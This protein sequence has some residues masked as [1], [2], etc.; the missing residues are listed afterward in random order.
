MAKTIKLGGMVFDY[1]V[2]REENR[3][4]RT[5]ALFRTQR[6]K[7]LF[8]CYKSVSGEKYRTYEA[9][10]T[11]AQGVNLDDLFSVRNFNV[12]SHNS[13]SYVLSGVV[14]NEKTGDSYYIKITANNRYAYLLL[15]Y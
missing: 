15:D 14:T 10:R 5:Q 3:S 2:Q 13:W 4:S 11:W 7:S 12:E 6:N 8:E 9:W 1:I